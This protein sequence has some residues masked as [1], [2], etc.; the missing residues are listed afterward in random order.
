M[1]KKLI[2]KIKKDL[3]LD[4]TI[5]NVKRIL[6]SAKTFETSAKYWENRYKAGGNSGAG[7]YNNFAEFKGEIINSFV[8]ENNIDSVIEFGCG[9]GNQLKYFSFNSYIGYDIS[10]KAISLCSDIFKNDKSKQFINLI[11]YKPVKAD[12][13]L[14]LD[15][16]YHLVEDDIFHDYMS[17]LFDSSKRFVIIYSSNGDLP[18]NNS[19]VDHVKDR[20]FTNWIE[21]E[22]PDFKLFKYIPNKYPYNG[23]GT[24]TSIADFYIYEKKPDD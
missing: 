18:K 20:Q 16:I 22:K 4:K 11:D 2:N 7:S 12:L 6:F 10:R 13:T 3:I 17:K 1:L 9:D 23:D 14:S 8:S 15:V 21:R 19:I 5:S 24:K